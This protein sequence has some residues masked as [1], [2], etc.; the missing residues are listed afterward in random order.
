MLKIDMFNHFFPRSYF[1]RF[2]NVP[3]AKD[4][5]KRMLHIPSIVDLDLRFRIM[6]E[7]SEYQQV[8]SLPMPPVESLATPDKSPELARNANDGLAELVQKYPQRFPGFIASLPLNNLEASLQEI[9]RA[10][11]QLGAVGIQ[12]FSN[13]QGKALDAPEFLPLFEE[14]ARRDVPVWLHPARGTNFTDYLSEKKSKYEIWWTFG[15]PYETS[16]AMSRL[17]FSGIFDRLPDLKI[18]THHLGGMI[19]YFEG[20]VGLGWDQLGT[21]TSDEDYGALLRSMKARPVD[22]FHKFYGDTALSGALP[23]SRCGIEFFG[24]DHV[25]FATDV[26]FDPKPGLFIQETI[27]VLDSLGLDPADKEKIYYGNALRLMKRAPRKANA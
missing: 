2:I 8:L 1:D 22:Y 9:E 18:I 7:Y 11:S 24:A 17:V 3:G 25:V 6:D 15:W 19:P 26:P 12:L 23:A 5:G 14:A 16:V 13:I 10:I 21:R 20:R 27:R 4:M